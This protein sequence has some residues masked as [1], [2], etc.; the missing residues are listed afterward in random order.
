MLA[1]LFQM[2]YT[3]IKLIEDGVI[4]MKLLLKGET[5]VFQ[6]T[7]EKNV[8]KGTT[9]RFSDFAVPFS[10]NGTDYLYNTFTKRLY[11]LDGE[12]LDTSVDAWYPSSEIE[13]NEFL[14]ELVKNL[15]LVPEDKDE[16][17]F[18]EGFLTIARAMAKRNKKKGF[19]TYTILPTTACNARCFYCFEQGIK[20][21]TMDD[22]TVDQTIRF[23][24]DTRQ[25]EQR[26]RICWFGGEPLIGEKIIDKI[27]AALREEGVDFVSSMISNGSLI[28]EEIIEKM[29]NDWNLKNIQ[30]TLDGVEEEYNRRKNYIFQYDSA[31]WHV[32]SRLKMIN[33]QTDVY[34]SIRVN[35]DEGNID[36]FAQMFEDLDPFLP[37]KDRVNI[38]LSPLYGDRKEGSDLEVIRKFESLFDYVDKTDYFLSLKYPARRLRLHYC[39]ADSDESVVIAPDGKLYACEN[40]HE[41]PFSTGTIWEGLTNKELVNDLLKVEKVAD[42]C[43]GCPWLPDCTS[44]SR[45]PH[46]EINCE[47]YMRQKME[48]TIKMIIDDGAFDAPQT[49]ETAEENE[50]C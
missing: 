49:G 3:D 8:V 36:G 27:C 48:H 35:I 28:N 40:V 31:Y 46:E 21:I 12:Q 30:I 23:I 15:F 26:I 13:G 38:S 14:T 45:C 9:Y 6:L 32:L 22:E 44:F 18:Y 1:F 11:A 10:H 5:L 4:H 24:L 37:N 20:Y 7:G 16:A 42:K 17:K 33:T 19:K 25:P 50:D 2:L 47:R 41:R 43:K 29:N 34:L 39:G